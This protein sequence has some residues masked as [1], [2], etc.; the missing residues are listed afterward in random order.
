MRAN[1]LGAAYQSVL[2]SAGANPSNRLLSMV[3][4]AVT[5]SSDRQAKIELFA[6]IGLLAGLV[7][8]ASLAVARERRKAR[9]WA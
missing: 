2:V 5:A 9:P 1:A 7:G 8:G 4:G 6:F 3:A